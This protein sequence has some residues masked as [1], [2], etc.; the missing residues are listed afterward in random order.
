[1]S[2]ELDVWAD[3]K[4]NFDSL[5]KVIDFI[6]LKTEKKII[7]Q[8]RSKKKELKETTQIKE[9]QYFTDFERIELNTNFAFCHQIKIY[10]QTMNFWA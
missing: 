9:I 6:E 10:S 5:V 3:H 8:S 7:H 1:M 4:I 2:V